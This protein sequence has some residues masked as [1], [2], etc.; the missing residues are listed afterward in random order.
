[1]ATVS[2]LTFNKDISQKI[3]KWHGDKGF[4]KKKEGY[5]TIHDLQTMRILVEETKEYK[6]WF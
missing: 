4:A 5:S 2:C 3:L 6:I 1:M